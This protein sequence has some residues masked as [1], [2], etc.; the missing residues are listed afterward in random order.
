M[1]L[2][3][4]STTDTVQPGLLQPGATVTGTV[5]GFV[6]NGDDF[7]FQTGGQ[8]Y[9]VDT[10]P[11][12]ASQLGLTV[13]ETVN[14]VVSEFD[15]ME[16][17]TRSISRGDTPVTLRSQSYFD[18]ITGYGFDEAEYLQRNPDVAAAGVDAWEH[19]TTF[20]AMEGRMP[21]LFDRD[22][23]LSQYADLQAASDAGYLPNP[24]EHYR[25]LGYQEGRMA[26]PFQQS[27]GDPLTNPGVGTVSGSVNAL[28]DNDEFLL[29][30]DTGT[31][32]VDSDLPDSQI[33]NL[34]PGE[35]VTVTGI[36]DDEDFDAFSITRE[37]GSEVVSRPGFESLT[38]IPNTGT[39]PNGTVSGSVNALV[40]ND[41]F[42]LN[43]DAGTVRVEAE[44]PDSQVLNVNPGDRVTVTGVYDDE[45][46]DAVSITR[47][48]GSSVWTRSNVD[49][50]EMYDDWDD[51]DSYD[52]RYDD[53]WDDND[54][55]DDD[56]YDDDR[57]DDDR[58]DDDWDD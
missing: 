45:D 7:L 26:T 33:L 37:D 12:P 39:L 6:D 41:E 20:G 58:Y 55:Y 44:L 48:D 8:N 36:Y 25:L 51:N 34:T 28:V 47:E 1:E 22:F 31:V 9:V 4:S 53:D 11:L 21:E 49:F 57:Y 40:D 13:G 17:D 32:L 23:Y 43:T 15:G 52:D 10:E 46:F 5:E 50:D 16:I 29:E 18:P 14:L 38:G 27:V 2:L 24:W 42:L 3:T 30:T 56:R 35:R 19:F 54:S